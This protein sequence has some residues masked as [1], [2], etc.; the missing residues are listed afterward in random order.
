MNL[1]NKLSLLRVALIPPALICLLWGGM[2]STQPEITVWLRAAA[3]VI[4]VVATATD[5]LDG[6]IARSRGLITNLGKLLDPLADKV[7]VA[8]VMI[9]LVELQVYPAW[10]VVLILA[11]E[12]LV[13]GLRMVAVAE[14]AVLAADSWGKHKTA[15]QLIALLVA[16]LALVVRESGRAAGT[17]DGTVFGISWLVP[18]YVPLAI[19]TLLTVISGWL[20]CWR[21]RSLLRE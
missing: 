3:L 9:A 17:W 11:R 14:G 7:L 19:A 20:Y 16:L 1:P 10:P 6:W 8:A 13:T 18:L 4:V 12:F 5:F 15:W 21:N 2:E